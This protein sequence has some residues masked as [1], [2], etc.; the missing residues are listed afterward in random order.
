VLYPASAVLLLRDDW[1]LR[2]AAEAGAVLIELT[3]GG[4]PPRW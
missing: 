2:D 3:F 4:T 1:I